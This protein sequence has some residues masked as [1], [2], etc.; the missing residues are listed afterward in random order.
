MA[1]AHTYFLGELSQIAGYNS[2][3]K[4]RAVHLTSE[5]QVLVAGTH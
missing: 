3:T 1:Y 2:G 5:W 4:H